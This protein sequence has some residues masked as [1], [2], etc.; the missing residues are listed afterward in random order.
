MTQERLHVIGIGDDGPAG[1][2]PAAAARIAAAV[3]LAGGERHLAFFPNFHGTR[4][5]IDAERERWLAELRSAYRQKP[6]VVLASGDP[7]FYGVGR[8]LLEAFPRDDLVFEPHV[9]SVQLAF[10]RLKEPWHDARVVSLHGRPIDC[11]L[12][13]LEEHASKIAILTD[14]Q[15]HPGAI[16]RFLAERRLDG[17]YEVAVCENLGGAEER[18]TRGTVSDVAERRFAPLCVVVLLR[19]PNATSVEPHSPLPLL[20]LPERTFAHRGDSDGGMIT[21]RDVRVLT[22]G[23]LELHAGDVV[24]DIGAGSGSVALEAARLSPSLR[25]FAIERSTIA[26][27]HIEENC[28]NLGLTRVQVVR[29]EAPEALAALPAPNAVFIGGSGGQLGNILEIAAT[30]LRTG[31]RLV[32]N[33]I[34]LENFTLA[35]EWLRQRHWQV[36]ASTVQLAHSRPLGS[37]TCFEPEKPITILRGRRP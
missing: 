32:L 22:L 31:G 10:A 7:L 18:V 9:S 3:V 36:D 17:A 1:L 11:L 13:A 2:P 4:I 34:T 37:L 5:V 21:K 19:D 24:W 20:G 12:P 33:C 35:W 15:N 16:A 27:L 26:A 14:V 23:Y 25:V 28:K 29:G 30:R 8:M 6:T